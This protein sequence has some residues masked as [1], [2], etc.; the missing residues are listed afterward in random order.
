[1]NTFKALRIY[2]QQG[3]YQLENLTLDQLTQGDVIIRVAYS[4]INYKDALAVAGKGAILKSYPL[5]GGIDL[6]G[7]VESSENE[8][9]KAGDKVLVS[10]AGLSEIYDGG[11][12]EIAR[13]PADCLCH[14]PSGI[15]LFEAMVMGTPAFTA[16]LALHRMEQNGQTPTMGPILITGASGGVGSLAVDIFNKAGYEVAALSGKRDQQEYLKQLGAAK[17]IDRHQL[18]MGTHPLESGQWGGAVDMVGGETLAWLTRTVKPWGNIASIGLT[19]GHQLNTTVMPFILRS[20]SLLGVNSTYCPPSLR[21]ATWQRL[22]HELKPQHL[23][24]ISHS[25]ETLASLTPRFSQILQGECR[26][27]VT[28][29]IT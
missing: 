4:G 17:V 28:V 29:K 18:K 7:T 20:I 19:G 3:H 5:V 27:R 6:S 26:G 23:D 16:A 11:Y 1:M 9:F 12:S 21:R 22:G 10:G 15:D 13:L 8:E 25:T 24:L 2:D 14:I